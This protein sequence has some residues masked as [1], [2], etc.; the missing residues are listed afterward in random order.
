MKTKLALSL[1]A[2]VLGTVALAQQPMRLAKSSGSSSVPAGVALVPGCMVS[3]INEAQVP[4]QEA[5]VLVEFNAVEGQRVK[6]GEVLGKIDDTQP[7]MQGLIATAEHKAA[8]EKAANDVDVRYADKASEVA[9]KECDK[10]VA[11]NKSTISAVS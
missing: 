1:V 4:G 6:S 2:A 10:S 8:L 7:Y 9:Y 11:A 5:G 3:L